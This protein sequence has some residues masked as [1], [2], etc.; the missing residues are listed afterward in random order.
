MVDDAE[1]EANGHRQSGDGEE[2]IEESEGQNQDE[3]GSSKAAP[4][5]SPASSLFSSLVK[6]LSS[7]L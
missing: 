4:Y 3:G 2:E 5:L 1:K 6:P 7:R